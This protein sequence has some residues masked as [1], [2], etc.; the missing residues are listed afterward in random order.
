VLLIDDDEVFRY[1][2]RTRLSGSR[3][4]VSEAAGGAEGLREA[5]A[6]PPNAIVLDLVM[7]EVSG[8]DVLT[9][10]RQDP[11][12]VD[13]PV[14]VLTSKRLSSEEQRALSPHAT[15]ILS[16]QVL[17]HAGSADEL[18]EALSTAGL[19]GERTDG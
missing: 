14:V 2:V 8:F 6:H 19:P 1:L 13:I 15:R 7:P 10:L 11:R 4:A 16:K 9:Q 3:F 17:S 5:R 12:T 18:L